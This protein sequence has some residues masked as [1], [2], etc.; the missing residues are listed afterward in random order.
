M[1]AMSPL[2]EHAVRLPVGSQHP[3]I[4]AG[5]TFTALRDAAPLPRGTSSW[6]IFGERI[7]E[8]V[9]AANAIAAHS[10]NTRIERAQ[11]VLADLAGRVRRIA[12]AAASSAPVIPAAPAPAP[13]RPVAS[14]LPDGTTRTPGRSLAVLYDSK[15]CIHARFC[16]TGE[17]KVF[18]ANV[19][20]GPWIFPDEGD[21]AR[22][23]ELVHACPSGALHY[24]RVD[25]KVEPVPPV[26]LITLRENG[27]YAIRADAQLAGESAGYRMTLCRCG[28]SKNKPFCDN[29]HIKIG[30]SVTGEPPSTKTDPLPDRGGPLA[31]DPEIDGP[32][33]FTGNVEIVSGTNRVVSRVTS[34]RLC[35]CGASATKPFCDNSHVRIGFRSD[36][37]ASSEVEP[38]EVAQHRVQ[39]G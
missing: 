27:P 10:K 30:F 24:D 8:L 23:V 15:R 22:V 28:A 14:R 33:V 32:L 4:N 25:G 36:N 20:K 3:G 5:V 11:R 6:R 21:P 19:T 37:S 2:A 26:N 18:H 35:R 39:S 1:H 13:I 34:A 17:P 29:S 9:D 38:V 31:I 16:V 12:P 7:D